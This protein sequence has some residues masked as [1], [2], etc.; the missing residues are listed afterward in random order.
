[1]RF[2]GEKERRTGLG[3]EDEGMVE[4]GLVRWREENEG[5]GR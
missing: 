1:L 2:L 5:E 3:I 4:R